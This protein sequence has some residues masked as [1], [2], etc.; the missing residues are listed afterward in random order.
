M[1]LN[2]KTEKNQIKK[3]AGKHDLG[4]EALTKRRGRAVNLERAKI[5]T[6]RDPNQTQRV[7][8]KPEMRYR[9]KKQRERKKST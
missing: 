6:Y 8:N 4:F 1:I 7:R 5:K 2:R 3:Q 9:K